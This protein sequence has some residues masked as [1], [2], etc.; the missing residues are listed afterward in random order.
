MNGTINNTIDNNQALLI[1]EIFQKGGIVKIK[2]ILRGEP[3]KSL[4]SVKIPTGTTVYPIRLKVASV[5]GNV[6]NC[7][8]YYYKDEFGEW[9]S[10]QR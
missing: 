3:L 2:E 1:T 5:D 6:T 7:D 9:A 8:L 4:V 10:V